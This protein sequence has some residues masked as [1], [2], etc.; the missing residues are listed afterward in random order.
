MTSSLRNILNFR[1][2]HRFF[3]LLSLAC[4]F[5]VDIG[6]AQNIVGTTTVNVDPNT[7]NVQ[8]LCE[9]DLDDP[10]AAYYVASVT[11]NVA[12]NGI[13]YTNKVGTSTHGNTGTAIAFLNIAG[14][15]GSTYTATGTHSGTII[16]TDPNTSQPIVGAYYDPY[17]FD[18]Y[19]LGTAQ[20]NPEPYPSTYDLYGPGPPQD[21]GSKQL[22]TVKSRAS[23]V[24]GYTPAQLDAFITSGKNMFS[25]HCDAV[26]AQVI[27]S[28]S[29]P[30][31]FDSLRATTFIQI[32]P[33]TPG[34][35]TDY[36]FG[37]DADTL[38]NQPNRPIRL[39]P[40]FYPTG[41]GFP[42]GFQSFVLIHEGVH[43]FTGWLDYHSA[44]TPN[45]P[46]FVNTF[47]NYGYRNITGQT[48]DFT[49]W[50]Q[51]GCI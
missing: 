36:P 46:D 28:Y 44:S 40:N 31:F 13:F 26:F 45:V 30:G 21:V 2:L 4:I 50:L 33:H 25:A 8:I 32:P 42:A 12:I 22:P 37:A 47:A 14:V 1:S 41:A 20:F 16:Y 18:S 11:C 29:N 23:E 34:A 38:V 35:P 19:F 17:N 5:L 10:A 24:A 3:Y 9:T 51:S 49:V 43:H 6:R 39:L 48:N 27:P 7:G 15:P